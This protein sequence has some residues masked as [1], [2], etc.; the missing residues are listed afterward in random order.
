[1]KNP[2]L[3]PYL[4]PQIRN[5]IFISLIAKA[6]NKTSRIFFRFYG[7]Y[8]RNKSKDYSEADKCSTTY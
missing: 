3:S 1:M 7:I 6:C 4:C 8:P 2:E 5:D